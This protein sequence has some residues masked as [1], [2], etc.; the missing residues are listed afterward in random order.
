MSHGEV[1]SLLRW[2]R[3]GAPMPHPWVASALPAHWA[4]GW[5]ERVLAGSRGSA[6]PS[7]A[8]PNGGVTVSFQKQN[9]KAQPRGLLGAPSPLCLWLPSCPRARAWLDGQSRG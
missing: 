3:P 2:A 5:L 4:E 6:S 9:V 8:L 1:P 7:L